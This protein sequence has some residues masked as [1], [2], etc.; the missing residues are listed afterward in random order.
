MGHLCFVK[1]SKLQQFMGDFPMKNIFKAPF[2]LDFHG[3]FP[4][5]L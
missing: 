1:I 2:L 5:E 4:A 3:I